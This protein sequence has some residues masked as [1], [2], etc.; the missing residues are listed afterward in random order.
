MSR[1]RPATFA[2]LL[3]LAG[4]ALAAP[5]DELC[6]RDLF[7]ADAGISGSYRSLEMGG[8]KPEE[9]C[10][11]WRRHVEALKKSSAAYGRCAEGAVK[12]R[13]TAELNGSVAD[14]QRLIGE[15]CKGR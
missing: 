7:M 10:A 1:K 14:F 2:A 3:I 13:K 4:R 6:K 9:Q 15:R 5:G 8:T 12:A 11:A